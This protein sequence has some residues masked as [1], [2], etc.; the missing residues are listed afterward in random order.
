MK[1]LVA[2]VTGASSGFGKAIATALL[3]KGYIVYAS[4]RRID[5][6]QELEEKGA[7]LV[8]MDITN[9]QDIKACVSKI[10][11]Q[12]AHIDI[13]VNSAGYGSYGAIEVVPIEEARKQFEVNVFA[14]AALTK[15]VLAHMRKTGGRIINISSGAGFS[16][17]PMGG[18]YA[19]SKHALEA[20]SDA[21]RCEVKRFGI[22][23]VLIEPGSVK[24]EFADI[25]MKHFDTINQIDVYK[26]QAEGFKNAFVKSY[27]NA[28]SSDIVTKAV[29]AAIT[30]KSPKIRYKV[31]GAGMLSFMKRWLP[32]A[33]FDKIGIMVM[34]Q[35]VK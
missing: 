6:M 5:S 35:N 30:S 16:A 9:H 7:I 34:G 13:L 10:I 1:T 8:P 28:P 29:L 27:K 26:K 32:D 3:E 20:F 4:A 33:V 31:A 24:T 2:L 25:A 18:W 17:F 21:L 19:A 11:S 23:V 22:D 15:E 12:K 14:L